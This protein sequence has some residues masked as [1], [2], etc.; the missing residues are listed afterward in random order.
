MMNRHS[1]KT[2]QPAGAILADEL[3]L[4]P[5][6]TVAQVAR[7]LRVSSTTVYRLVKDGALPCMRIGHA[8]RFTRSDVETLLETHALDADR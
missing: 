2:E 4:E 7:H 1:E 8:L 5:L 6:F 3:G